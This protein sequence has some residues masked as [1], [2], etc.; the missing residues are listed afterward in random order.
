MSRFGL[1]IKLEVLR[2]TL[3]QKD[4]AVMYACACLPSYNG[5]CL[6]LDVLA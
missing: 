4:C 1:Y 5:I 3:M 2:I 6:I